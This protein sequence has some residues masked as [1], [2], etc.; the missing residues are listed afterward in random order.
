MN[1]PVYR[2]PYSEEDIQFVFEHTRN[3]L[4]SGYL[5]D[6]GP[7]IS[8][9]ENE[10]SEFVDSEYSIA[11]NSCT[12]GLQAVLN[13]ISVESSTVV[14]PNY[15]FYASPMSVINE[16]GNVIFA[17][18]DSKTFSL[19]LDSIKRKVRKDTKAVMLVHVG[20]YVSDEIFKIKQWCDDNSIFLLEDA[21]CAAGTK[22]DG[23]SA[24]TIG[25]AGVFS[26]HHSKVLTSGE[27]GMICTSDPD[28][29]SR[30]RKIR[31]IGL[32]RSINNFEVFC[33]GSNYKMSEITAVL[34]LLHVN[35]ANSI[36]E[37]RRRIAARYDNEIRFTNGIKKFKPNIDYSTSPSYY[38]YIVMTESSDVKEKLTR[39][40]MAAGI[41]LPPTVYGYNCNKQN[42]SS[43]T[44]ILNASDKFKESVTA[45][46][47]HFC[48]NMYNSLS[49][50]EVSYII[51]S[52]NRAVSLL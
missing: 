11:V 9:L 4:E 52:V 22:I 10:W 49:D 2:L 20:G 14:V 18:I 32:D 47:N 19:T 7:Y 21:A 25:H 51:S 29:A 40:L 41:S 3:I 23:V 6:G 13:A 37:E 17:D 5:T 33:R 48:L 38:K 46:K 30:L 45:S 28:L 44:N 50:E 35:K 42:F 26:F 31:A 39:D 1:I 12:T 16:G 15:T 24:G 36:L 43:H 8:R 27:G 34:A